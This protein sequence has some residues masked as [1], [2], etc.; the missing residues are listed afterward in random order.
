MP[1]ILLFGALKSDSRAPQS[2]YIIALTRRNIVAVLLAQHT[3]RR[4]QDYL[5]A[6]RKDEF[7]QANHRPL[8]WLVALSRTL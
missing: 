8:T 1:Q 2:D 4:H 5:Q 3:Q 7:G 6:F